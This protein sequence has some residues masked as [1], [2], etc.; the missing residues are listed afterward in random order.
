MAAGFAARPLLATRVCLLCV[1]LCPGSGRR[2]GGR[3]G[4]GGGGVG[5]AVVEAVLLILDDLRRRE[6]AVRQH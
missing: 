5:A 4:W 6:R 3:R 1:A 2:N